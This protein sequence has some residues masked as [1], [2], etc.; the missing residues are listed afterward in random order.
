MNPCAPSSVSICFRTLGCRLNQ[1]ETSVLEEMFR[2]RGYRVA[3]SA[4]SADI[5][6]VNTC[7]VT[8]VGERKCRQAIRAASRHAHRPAVVVTGCYAETDGEYLASLPG[9]RL[10]VGTADKMRLPELVDAMRREDAGG[11]GASRVVR[12]RI[13]RVPFRSARSGS[14]AARGD[15]PSGRGGVSYRAAGSGAGATRALLKVQDGCDSACSYCIVP[16]SRGPARSRV[17][18]DLVHEAGELAARG[19]RE[20]V[21]T[22]VNIGA[23]ADDGRDLGDVL[24]AV[25]GIDGLD[26]VRVS[27][28]EPGTAEQTVLDRM[29][30]C[31]KI[32]RHLHLPMQHGDDR[33]LERMRRRYTAGEYERIV[34]AAASLV[35][36]ICIGADVIVGFPGEDD[37][38]FE[39]TVDLVEQLPLA[40]LHV[41]TFSERRGTIASRFVDRVDPRTAA[42]RSRRLRSI[43]RRKR[44]EH[45]GGMVG[46]DVEI[47]VEDEDAAG[48]FRGWTD[49]YVRLVGDRRC[50]DLRNR[51]VRARV[52][53]VATDGSVGGR[54]LEVVTP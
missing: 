49:S 31:T 2:S 14:V 53:E 47:L 37:A 43:S 19:Y 15:A 51:R 39:R 13:E 25:A 45:A 42:G 5:C 44:R 20:I 18:E 1:A 12:C 36:G 52:S 7:C 40:Y 17:F 35:P 54:L 21:L 46:R 22:G 34:R 48:R 6:I 8:H 4:R 30:R 27:S 41:F 10:V 24:G 16:R 3:P 28:V 50:G 33:I 23:Y 11:A 9:V 38:A 32:C 26:R 29:T